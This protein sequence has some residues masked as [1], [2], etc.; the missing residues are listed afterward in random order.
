[1]HMQ[2]YFLEKIIV[3]WDNMSNLNEFRFKWIHTGFIYVL[4]WSKI[5]VMCLDQKEMKLL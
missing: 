1:M 4:L 5:M 3:L 2:H